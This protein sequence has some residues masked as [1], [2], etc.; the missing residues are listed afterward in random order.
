[1]LRAGSSARTGPGIEA[2][3]AAP[4][5]PPTT[6]RREVGAAASS[7]SPLLPAEILEGKPGDAGAAIQSSR[8]PLV[9][10]ANSPRPT[11]CQGGGRAPRAG[12]AALRLGPPRGAALEEA[13]RDPR[14]DKMRDIAAD[15][16]ISLPEIFDKG[17]AFSEPLS[18]GSASPMLYGQIVSKDIVVRKPRTAPTWK[19]EDAKARF[20]EVV[21]RARAEGPQRVTVRGRDSVVVVAVEEFD[22]LRAGAS[23]RRPL[24]EFLRSLELDDL[25][26][27]REPD[28]GR[29]VAL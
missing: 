24:V 26:L 7:I 18:P 4:Q 28:Y 19:L 21:R 9:T 15:A 5:I 29:D 12:G 11:L 8:K 3:A 6:A 2:I 1:M 20:S 25:D 16:A 13:G 22:R 27:A 17:R 14:A 23:P 10:P